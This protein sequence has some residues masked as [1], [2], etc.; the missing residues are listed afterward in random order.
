MLEVD[1]RRQDVKLD[2]GMDH[3]GTRA[4]ENA[5]VRCG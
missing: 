1:G 2:V 4:A 5:D 3:I